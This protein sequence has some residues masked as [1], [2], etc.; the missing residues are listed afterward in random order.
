M[1]IACTF[2]NPAKV[3]FGI[4]LYCKVTLFPPLSFEGS[5]YSSPHKWSEELCSTSMRG[6]YLLNFIIILLYE[7]VSLLL[8]LFI[9]SIT[10]FYQYELIETY[11]P[12]F[13]SNITLF[14]QFGL[15]GGLSVGS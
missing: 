4:F 6:D 2:G 13:T 11:M 9:E 7:D 3:V 1:L 14:I 5:P 8:V 12:W 10:Y 15:L